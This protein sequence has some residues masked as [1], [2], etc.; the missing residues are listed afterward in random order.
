M[1]KCLDGIETTLTARCF[2]TRYKA[3]QWIQKHHNPDYNYNVVKS[4]EVV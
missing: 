3:I 1:N 2:P 4:K